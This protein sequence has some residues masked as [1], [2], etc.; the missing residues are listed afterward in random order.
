MMIPTPFCSEALP[1]L[2]PAM[3]SQLQT[4]FSAMPPQLEPLLPKIQSIQTPVCSF[5]VA[6]N[7]SQQLRN[8]QDTVELAKALYGRPLRIISS[9]LCMHVW[10]IILTWV[11]TC[12]VPFIS[13]LC[14]TSLLR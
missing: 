9:L 1:H 12:K 3:Q 14:L 2:L 11:Y 8:L 7:V 6:K 13:L 5:W 10:P 4:H